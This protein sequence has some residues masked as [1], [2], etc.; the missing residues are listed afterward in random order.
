MSDA[1]LG[2]YLD[3]WLAVQPQQRIALGFVDPAVRD[4]HVALAALEQEII[5]AAYAIREPQVAAVKL[6]WWAEELA[7][8]AVS[9][10]RHPLTKLLFAQAV[11]RTIPVNV[12]LAPVLAAMGQ[13][14]EGTSADFASQVAATSQLHAA[15]AA[16][17]THWWFGPDADASRAAS[18]AT[19]AH[20][21]NALM[22]LDEDVE[23][24][25]LPLPMARLAKF[26][27]TRVLLRKD[28]PARRDAIKAQLRDLADGF[29][30]AAV[31]T[32]P[33]SVFRAVESDDA[34]HLAR[35][36]LRAAEPLGVL[37]NR[38]ASGF[39]VLW[40][41]WRAARAWRRRLG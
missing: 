8:A 19:H 5:A 17:E 25:R 3:K 1:A 22:R 23:R 13:L 11:A 4:G 15:L 21:L 39:R 6:N 41:A 38:P 40:Q 14:E 16:L 26:G 29:A 12:W 28:S 37:Q 27:L 2:S 34:R 33:L 35:R 10:G 18:I 32:A 31:G 24:E 7:G 30:A 20:L 36:A 9:G